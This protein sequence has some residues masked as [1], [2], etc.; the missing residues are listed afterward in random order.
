M[1]FGTTSH[2]MDNKGRIFFPAKMRSNMSERLIICRSTEDC[3]M[4]FSEEEWESFNERV[5]QL[6]YSKGMKLR[7]YFY[8][9]M[10]ESTIDNQG[11]LLISQALRE[12]VGLEKDIIVAGAQT[13]AQIWDAAKWQAYDES[14]TKEE[15]LSL[16]DEQGF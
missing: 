15:V 11:R 1:L 8:S 5:R 4:V 6:S 12:L 9:S 10:Q 7:N 16:M 2:T 14:I 3:L 13:H